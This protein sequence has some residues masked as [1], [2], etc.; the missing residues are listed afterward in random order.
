MTLEERLT[1]LEAMVSK[2]HP[3]VV[4]NIPKVV[5]NG[6][7]LNLRE[8][9]GGG[10]ITAMPLGSLI[11]I[12]EER[13]NW[14]T[15]EWVHG[16]FEGQEGWCALPY[17]EDPNYNQ[18][19]YDT[20]SLASIFQLAYIRADDTKERLNWGGA[21]GGTSYPMTVVLTDAQGDVQVGKRMKRSHY[22]YFDALNIQQG[23]ES[24]HNAHN[25]ESG[26]FNGQ[27]QHD[28]E[29]PHLIDDDDL[30]RSEPITAA[31]NYVAVAEEYAWGIGIIAY[32]RGDTFPDPHSLSFSNGML[33][34]HHFSA[35]HKD[36]D[37]SPVDISSPTGVPSTVINP[38]VSETGKVPGIRDK[39]D[40]C[41]RRI[42]L[43]PD[44]LGTTLKL[45]PKW[46]IPIRQG[47]GV[48]N[49]NIGFLARGQKFVV[50]Y[51]YPTATGL[52]CKV[53]GGYA[54]L[55]YQPIPGLNHTEWS[56][57]FYIDDWMPLRPWNS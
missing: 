23:R 20:D 12:S 42:Y 43:L 18:D 41:Q 16:V 48:E 47:P 39:D 4:F 2:Y 52:W 34:N 25:I 51:F 8:Y 53:E 55:G 32:H 40:F 30:P 10:V 13:M 35:I 28:W 5:K 7:G 29:N 6:S 17:L 11:V 33:V 19:P 36:F 46:N 3:S 24:R 45:T 49:K 21:K 57:E 56:T 9:P 44:T 14:N 15:I 26:I 27:P 54:A 22:S 38:V 31:C 50:E 1:K 37:K